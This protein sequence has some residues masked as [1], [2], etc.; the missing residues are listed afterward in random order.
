MPVVANSD[1]DGRGFAD[2]GDG[3]DWDAFLAM[4][5]GHLLTPP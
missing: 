2:P 3:F 1:I 5:G 4:A